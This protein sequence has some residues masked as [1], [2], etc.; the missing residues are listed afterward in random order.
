MHNKKIGN[1]TTTKQQ[2]NNTYNNINKDNNIIFN[3][4]L[5]K[6]KQN[7]P[8]TYN[9][10][11]QRIAEIKNSVDYQKLSAEEQDEL[12]NKLM[13]MRRSDL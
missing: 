5:N 10:K 1:K 12:F 8:Q 7:F 6:Y 3:L 9:Q 4:L 2:Q 11:I 13:A